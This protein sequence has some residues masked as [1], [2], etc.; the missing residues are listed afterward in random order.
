MQD[1]RSIL[2][3]LTAALAAAPL[4]R[5]ARPAGDLQHASAEAGPPP[6]LDFGDGLKVPLSKGAFLTLWE[7]KTF[8]I[9]YGYGRASDGLRANGKAVHFAEGAMKLLLLTLAFSPERLEHVDGCGWRLKD[10][11]ARNYVL[12][13]VD[14]PG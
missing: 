12:G 13:D 11:K 3:A 14:L 6:Y 9:T 4:A 5:T 2:L 8:W 10:P 7:G 1:R